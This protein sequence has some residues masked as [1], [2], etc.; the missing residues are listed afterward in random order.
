MTPDELNQLRTQLAPVIK[1]M[2]RHQLEGKAW[3]RELQVRALRRLAKRDDVT[4]EIRMA[5]GNIL[6]M[7]LA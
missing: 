3:V 6:L 1:G 4:P 2:S 5:I 7:E